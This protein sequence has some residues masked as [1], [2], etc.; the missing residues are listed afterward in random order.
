MFWMNY[1][2]GV[3]TAGAEEEN[4]CPAS[5]FWETIKIGIA[6]VAIDWTVDRPALCTICHWFLSRTLLK[7][8][9]IW[10]ILYQSQALERRVRVQ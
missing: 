5:V 10:R 8:Y 7:L 1:G 9:V 3:D 6:D 4:A 2:N